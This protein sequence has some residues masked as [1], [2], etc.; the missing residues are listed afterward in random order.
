MSSPITKILQAGL[1][2]PVPSCPNPAIWHC[3]RPPQPYSEVSEIQNLCD[4]HAWEWAE[5][6]NCEFPGGPLR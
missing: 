1:V 6:A 5:S 4:A 2:C 3:D